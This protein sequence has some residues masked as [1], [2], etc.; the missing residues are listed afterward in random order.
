MVDVLHLFSTA[1]RSRVLSAV[2]AALP[3]GGP[4]VVKAQERATDPRYALTYAQ[5]IL[6]SSLRFTRGAPRRFH[7][8]SRE[9]ALAL[10]R[11]AGFLMDVVPMRARPYTDVIYLGRKAPIIGP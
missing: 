8:P 6:S 4:V 3:E 11:E 9:E 1:D 5:E 10:F 7:F 2:A